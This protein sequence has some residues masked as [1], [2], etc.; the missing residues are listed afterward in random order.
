MYVYAAFAAFCALSSA[1]DILS[2]LLFKDRIYEANPVFVL[3]VYSIITQLVAGICLFVP[4]RPHESHNIVRHGMAFIW[5]NVFTLAAFI[6]YFLAIKS[7]LGAAVNS[8]V[9]YGSSPIFT[10]IIGALYAKERLSRAFAISATAS[11][12][13]IVILSIPRVYIDNFSPLWVAGLLMCFVSSISSACYRVGYK[14]LL[15]QGATKSSIIF[16]RLFG[17]TLTLGALLLISPD[18]IRLDIL[19]QVSILGLIGFTAPL[20][21]TLIIME[22]VTIRSFAMLLFCVPALTFIASASIGYA[23][24]FP[25]DLI[26]AALAIFGAVFHERRTGA[27]T[28]LSRG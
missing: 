12:V 14:N 19:G 9:D 16:F 27:S 18:K 10:A 17:T 25:S 26:A 8:F 24:F 5:L 20:F 3:F 7:P 2:E 4:S 23:T 1:R 11:T 28:V 21:L 6:F 22:R 13:G 15:V